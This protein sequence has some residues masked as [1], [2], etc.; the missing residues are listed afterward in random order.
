[1][2]FVPVTLTLTQWPSYVNMTCIPWWCTGWAKM[3]FLCRGFKSYRLTDRQYRN[4]I[5]RHFTG[6]Q[7]AKFFP[8]PHW[9]TG[10]HWPAFSV[11]VRVKPHIRGQCITQCACLHPAFTG[12]HFCRLRKVSQAELAAWLMVQ[13]LLEPVATHPSTNQARRRAT[14]L[15]ETNVL[16]LCYTALR[17]KFISKK[18][19]MRKVTNQD[20]CRS[21]TVCSRQKEQQHQSYCMCWQRQFQQA[22]DQTRGEPCWCPAWTHRQLDHTPYH[23]H[24]A[25]LHW[26]LCHTL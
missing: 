8:E 11:A 18:E 26:C 12:T 20:L 2:F 7:K 23:W 19:Q 10:W 3:N 15:I 13:M 21:P 16:P 22:D 6:S 9:T 14:M 17:R 1:M 4:Y 5:P 25:E 24:F